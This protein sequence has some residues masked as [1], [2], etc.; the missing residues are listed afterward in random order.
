VVSI[1]PLQNNIGV[2][3]YAIPNNAEHC[4][5]VW[6][7]SNLHLS[8]ESRYACIQKASGALFQDLGTATTILP[9]DAAATVLAA[10]GTR[11]CVALYSCF[12]QVSRLI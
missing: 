5:T 8:G 2:D 3:N 11:V 9:M 7:I 1:E 6:R 4:C 10:S 12:M